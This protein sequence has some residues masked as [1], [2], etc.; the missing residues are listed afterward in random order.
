MAEVFQTVLILSAFGFF[1]TALLLCLKP[2]TAKKL[3]A[4]WQ[5]CIWIVVLISMVMPIYKLIPVK[6]TQKIPMFPQNDIVQTEPLQENL[7]IPGTAAEEELHIEQKQENLKSDHR[8][9]LIDLLPFVWLS[10]VCFYLF[11]VICSY[12]FYISRKRKKSFEITELCAFNEVKSKLKIKRNI[13]IRMSESFD[14]PMLVG[15]IYPV[16]YIPYREITEEHMRM[17]LLHEL[18]H[19]KRKDLLVK[20]FS[21]FVNAIHW[22]NPL[23]YVLCS[24]ISEA[25]EISCDMAVT[26]NMSEEE[27]K[28]YMKTILELAQ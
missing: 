9:K 3:P 5:Y 7:E 18:I 6:E 23:A 19:Y 16:I 22:F 15:I 17:V 2:L 10:G 25:C 28:S 27:R 1:I 11:F 4:K 12:F 8:I 13:K 14:S 20:W 26:K 24:N 21:L